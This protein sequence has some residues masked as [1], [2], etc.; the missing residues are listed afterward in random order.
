MATQKPAITPSITESSSPSDHGSLKSREGTDVKH[1]SDLAPPPFSPLATQENQRME[2]V[3]GDAILR[4][5]G[6]RKGPKKD[7]YDLDAVRAH[8]ITNREDWLLT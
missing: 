8:L 4:F 1:A 2:A 3:L 5:V 6:I 7:E